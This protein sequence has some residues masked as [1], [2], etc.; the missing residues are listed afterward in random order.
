MRAGRLPLAAAAAALLSVAASATPT[1]PSPPPRI[2][3]PFA[4][5]T[6][7]E[8]N[9][10]AL[11]PRPLP[12]DPRNVSTTWAVEATC[13]GYGPFTPSAVGAASAAWGLFDVPCGRPAEPAVAEWGYEFHHNTA[14]GGLFPVCAN[15]SGEAYAAPPASRADAAGRVRAYWL[16]RAAAAR[17]AVGALPDA[18]VLS[19]IGH[20]LYGGYSA[21]WGGLGV[22]GTEVGENINSINAHVAAT[23]GA[24]RQAGL[25]WLLDFSSWLAG[26]ILDYSDARFWGAASS[27]VGGHSL[28]LFRRAAVAAFMGGAGRFVA[29]AG[30]VNYFLQPP[31]NATGVLALSPLGEAGADFYAFSHPPPG[32]GGDVEAYR[33]IAYAPLALLP[34][35][36]AG[37]G[38]GFFYD[39]LAWDAFPLSEGDRRLAAWLAAAWPGSFTVQSQT[40]GPQSEAYYQVGGGAAGGCDA[41]DLLLPIVDGDT[42]NVTAD[43]GLTP[44]LLA[45]YRAVVLAGVGSVDDNATSGGGGA[46]SPPP[47]SM[48][49]A[50]AALLAGYVSRGGTLV[51][52]VDDVGDRAWWPDGFFGAAWAPSPAAVVVTAA[53]DEQTGWTAAVPG[54]LP[55][56]L[57][58]LY[59]L[60]ASAAGA[61]GGGDG[62][63]ASDPPPPALGPSAAVLLSF[64]VVNGTGGARQPAAVRNSVGPGA[65]VTLLGLR[66]DVALGRQ[67]LGLAVHLLG[68]LAN[69][70]LPVAVSCSGAAGGG[71]GNGTV[72]DGTPSCGLQVLVN[73]GPGGWNVTLVNNHGVVKQPNA[74][75]AV[76]ASQLRVVDVALRPGWGAVAAA[77][78][79]SHG[80]ARAVPLPV[81]PGG[82]GVAGVAIPAGDLAV[83]SLQLVAAAAAEAGVALPAAAAAA[84]RG[85][86]AVGE[87]TAR[88][89][90]H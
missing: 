80:P 20:Y 57:T 46:G 76:N 54:P 73:R 53:H 30:A 28:S 8:L 10:T 37:A 31:P 15:L 1:G 41:L 52:D 58:L 25:P 62:G 4:P 44:A 49:P 83:V 43:A 12:Y 67:A 86:P 50:L 16:C 36:T 87:T 24:G 18:P 60:V 14:G 26:F 61:G 90:A 66:S 88:Y 65:V 21:A 27:P 40:G 32:A 82:G 23:R 34:S 38:L 39:S 35:L 42:P 85:R 72:D 9:A 3:P 45:A 77:W 69:D 84:G 13:C 59:P 11:R 2:V 71:P 55:A 74:S 75:V 6:F 5:P 79:T 47:T 22:V 68:R 51:L 78:E 48:T 70:T 29:E 33:G 63:G 17:A 89:R 64:D 7:A 56:A 19:E 81:A